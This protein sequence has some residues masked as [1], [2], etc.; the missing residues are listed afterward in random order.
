MYSF[1]LK[2]HE[3]ITCKDMA[4]LYHAG[5]ALQGALYLTEERLVFVGYI[6]DITRKYMLEVPLAHVEKV[7]VGRSLFVVPNVLHVRTIREEEYKFILKRR[8]HW[9]KV[10]RTATGMVE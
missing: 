7:E 2:E 9:Q 5:D 6:M 1:P 3:T 10:I 8:D 4:N